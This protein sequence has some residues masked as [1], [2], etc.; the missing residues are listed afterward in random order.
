VGSG[1]SAKSHFPHGKSSIRQDAPSL[2]PEA[3]LEMTTGVLRR[4]RGT[5]VAFDKQASRTEASRVPKVIVRNGKAVGADVEPIAGTSCRTLRQG[6][7]PIAIGDVEGGILGGMPEIA[8]SIGPQR[9]VGG[10]AIA[11]SVRADVEGVLLGDYKQ[12]RSGS[13]TKRDV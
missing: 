10:S 12:T 4:S 9:T 6:G 3:A 8:S 2:N 5:G 7:A 13:A 1:A 11:N